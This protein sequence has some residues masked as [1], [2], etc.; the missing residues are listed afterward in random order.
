MSTSRQ[1]TIIVDI[2]KCT[3][4]RRCQLI[5]SFQ[6]NEEFNLDKACIAVAEDD[7]RVTNITFA[8]ECDV[9]GLCVRCCVYGAL[10][11]GRKV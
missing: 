4:C 6:H 10:K 7:Y 5:C 8:D 1:H 11:F 2:Q 9:C 3:G